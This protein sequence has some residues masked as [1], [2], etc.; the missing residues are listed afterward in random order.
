MHIFLTI[1]MGNFTI[2]VK[3]ITQ[4]F[5]QKYELHLENVFKLIHT[6]IEK[7]IYFAQFT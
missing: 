3:Y 7:N 6:V 4:F 2:C 5:I 1:V